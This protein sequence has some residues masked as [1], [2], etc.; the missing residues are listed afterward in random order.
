MNET[1]TAIGHFIAENIGSG[2]AIALLVFGARRMI[3]KFDKMDLLLRGDGN[4]TKGIAESMRLHVSAEVEKVHAEV[5]TLRDELRAH[6]TGE[7]SR[8]D[9]ALEAHVLA[10]EIERDGSDDE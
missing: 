1:T 8:I 9:S 5:K 7:R 10:C 2:T 4:G 6:A 3:A